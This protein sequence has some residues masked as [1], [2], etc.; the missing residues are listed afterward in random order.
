LRKNFIHRPNPLETK[1]A[2]IDAL[3]EEIRLLKSEVYHARLEAKHAS[4]N[5]SEIEDECPTCDNV[6]QLQKEFEDCNCD[7]LEIQSFLKNKI[8]SRKWC[9]KFQCAHLSPQLCDVKEMLSA[10]YCRKEYDSAAAAYELAFCN[11]VD[12]GAVIERKSQA[13]LQFMECNPDMDPRCA[14]FINQALALA[15]D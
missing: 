5:M 13:L 10:L 9:R 14:T 1:Q 8:D 2:E 7:A 11:A 12:S 6:H 15:C 3:K 4:D